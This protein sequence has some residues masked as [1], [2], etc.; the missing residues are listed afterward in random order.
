[1]ANYILLGFLAGC[2]IL[3]LTLPLA[4]ADTPAGIYAESS[5]RVDD[6]TVRRVRDRS[7]GVVCYL[8]TNY[9]YAQAPYGRTVAIDCL[10][11]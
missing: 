2:T 4:H 9:A 8:V 1:M 5:M 11:E 7:N 10:K 3:V 6:A